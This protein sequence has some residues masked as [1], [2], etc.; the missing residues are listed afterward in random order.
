MVSFWPREAGGLC[1]WRV[2]VVMQVAHMGHDDK[3]D[4]IL[5]WICFTK[6]F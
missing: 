5:F 2:V 1:A 3:T 4:A 6:C